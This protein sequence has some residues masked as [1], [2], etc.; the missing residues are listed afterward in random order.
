MYCIHVEQHMSYVTATSPL[1]Y[2]LSLSTSNQTLH[3]FRVHRRSQHF[4]CGCTFFLAKIWWPFSSRHAL[5]HGLL[6]PRYRCYRLPLYL[7]C[8]GA[9]HQIQPNFCLI[10]RKMPGKIFSV[11]LGVQV[12]PCTSLAMLMRQWSRASSFVCWSFLNFLANR[13]GSKSLARSRNALAQLKLRAGGTSVWLNR[14]T[15]SNHASSTRSGNL[16][17]VYAYIAIVV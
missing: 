17:F 11:A 10:S 4:A 12:T 2:G 16:L 8:G 7:I 14:L 9:S 5:L 15:S 6:P 1:R 13:S 3:L